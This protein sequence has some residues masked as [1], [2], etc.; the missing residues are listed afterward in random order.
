MEPQDVVMELEDV[1]IEAGDVVEVEEIVL[2]L[3]EVTTLV[4]LLGANAATPSA[5]ACSKGAANEAARP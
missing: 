2:E 3:V 5:N 1:V 4:Q